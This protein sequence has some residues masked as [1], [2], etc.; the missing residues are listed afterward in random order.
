MVVPLHRRQRSTGQVVI[1]EGNA[2]GKP[3]IATRV[4]G[5]VDYVRPGET[6]LLC[7]PY[8]ALDMRTAIER[9]IADPWKESGSDAMRWNWWNETTRSRCM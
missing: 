2:L 8:D 4:V 3:A 5:T 7:E 1:L 9:L 6:G